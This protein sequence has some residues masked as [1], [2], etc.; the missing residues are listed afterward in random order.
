MVAKVDDR[1]A[2]REK[3]KE[4]LKEKER[5]RQQEEESWRIG[6]I[7]LDEVRY[8]RSEETC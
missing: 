7:S 5:A 8:G 4:R 1:K 3:E 2:E 6:S